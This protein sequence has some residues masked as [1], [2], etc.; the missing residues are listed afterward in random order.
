ML[1]AVTGYVQESWSA[2]YRPIFGFNTDLKGLLQPIVAVRFEQGL[3]NSFAVLFKQFIFKGFQE[4]A[5]LSSSVMGGG[6]SETNTGCQ[7]KQARGLRDDLV[8]WPDSCLHTP[9][10]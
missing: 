9:E 2:I 4:T 7:E 3:D 1:E 8:I 10:R 6:G 5:S